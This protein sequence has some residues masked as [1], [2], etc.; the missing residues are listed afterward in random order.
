[1]FQSSV[2]FDFNNSTEDKKTDFDTV[3]FIFSAEYTILY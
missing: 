2:K 1:M 3:F